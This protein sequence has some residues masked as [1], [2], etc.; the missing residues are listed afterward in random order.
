M[1]RVGFQAAAATLAALSLSLAAACAQG[2]AQ[3]APYP[4]MAPLQQY[5]MPDRTEIALAKSAAP[6]AI[7]AHATVLVFSPHGYQVAEKGSNGFTCLVERSWTKSFDDTDFWNSKLRAP[8]CYNSGASRTVLPYTIKRTNMV[9]AGLTE[10]AIF[11]QIKADVA[12]KQLP[13]PEP[14]SMAYM[15]S[16]EQDLATNGGRWMAHVMFYAPKADSANDGANW[17]ADLQGS[18]VIFDTAHRVNPEPWT[19]FF[20]PVSKWSDGSRAPTM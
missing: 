4:R 12:G 1:I 13:P 9:L 15:M 2:Q 17:G 10:S 14:G 6:P 19:L 18:P 8:V 11:D 3:S 7:S 5:L 20:V 16:K